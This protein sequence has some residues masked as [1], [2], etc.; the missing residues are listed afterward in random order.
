MVT[1]STAPLRLMTISGM[2]FGIISFIIGVIYLVHKLIYWQRF[3]AGSAPL[4]IG[5]FFIGSLL[6][7]SIG[8][9]GEYIAV[10]LRKVTHELDVQL[11]ETI[12][13][14]KDTEQRIS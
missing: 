14:E 13:A 7:F 4:L 3:Q 2:L 9:L 5:F 6:L 8:L 10:I 11:K 1:T 12:N